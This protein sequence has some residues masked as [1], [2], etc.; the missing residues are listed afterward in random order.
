MCEPNAGGVQAACP[1]SPPG[2]ARAELGHRR[3]RV[4]VCS[5][6]RGTHLD[7]LVQR[8]EPA[9]LPAGTSPAPTQPLAV[10]LSSRLV[11]KTPCPAQ[12]RPPRSTGGLLRSHSRPLTLRPAKCSCRH[13]WHPPPR[14]HS[15]GALSPH[16]QEGRGPLGQSPG[17]GPQR[18]A[19]G[20]DMERGLRPHPQRALCPWRWSGLVRL[21]PSVKLVVLQPRREAEGTGL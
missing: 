19:E 20:P 11:S 3:F 9:S 12:L 13:P 7:R 17:T 16:G 10:W 18:K 15:R 1:P 21:A 2:P 5:V 4:A 6:D 8:P 14:G